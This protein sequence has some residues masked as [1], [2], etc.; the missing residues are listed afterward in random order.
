VAGWGERERGW[1][2][3][4][5]MAQCMH[6]WINEFKNFKRES[7]KCHKSQ[8]EKSEETLGITEITSIHRNHDRAN[9]WEEFW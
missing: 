4:G 8:T 2:Y 6:M 3:E 7:N 5:E 9:I 1:G